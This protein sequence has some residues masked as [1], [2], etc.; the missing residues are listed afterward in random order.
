[1]VMPQCSKSRGWG[2][3]RLHFVECGSGDAAMTDQKPKR[4]LGS[5]HLFTLG[6]FVYFLGGYT[7]INKYWPDSDMAFYIL[8]AVGTAG[9]VVILKRRRNRG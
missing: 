9:G 7:L 6:C 1:M 3:Q 4:I 8:V 5:S 2:V